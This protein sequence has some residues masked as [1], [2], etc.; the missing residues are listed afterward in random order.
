MESREMAMLAANALSNKKALD[1]I[2]IDIGAK[3]GFAD[4]LV[5]AAGGSLRQTAALVEEVEFKL[6]K[7]GIFVKN[8]E[9]N[10]QSGW[11]LMDYGDIIVNIFTTEMREK[12]NMEK[13]WGD[14]EV[15]RID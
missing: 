6:E 1:T 14:C 8:V 12:Y 3:S 9:G 5:I 2:I 15:T 7:E 4:Y 13:V 11:L 10:K